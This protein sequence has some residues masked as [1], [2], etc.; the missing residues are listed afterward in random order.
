LSKKPNPGL[1]LV[2]GLTLSTVYAEVGA[3][4]TRPL[5]PFGSYHFFW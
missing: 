1:E 2:V 3:L 5:A 4:G